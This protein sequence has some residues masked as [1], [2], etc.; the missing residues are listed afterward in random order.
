MKAFAVR[1]RALSHKLK[2]QRLC[3]W[4]YSGYAD[5]QRMYSDVAVL[6]FGTQ[7][8]YVYLNI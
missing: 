6:C 4:L 1:A 8:V 7:H 3:W 5:Y 2:P